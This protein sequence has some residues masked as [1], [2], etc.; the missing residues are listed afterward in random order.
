LFRQLLA[1]GLKAQLRLRS[2]I[3][4]QLYVA[5]DFHPE[6][7]IR[8]VGSDKKYPEIPTIQSPTEVLMSTLE[9]VPLSELAD[10]LV[11]VT[12]GIERTVNS[13]EVASSLKNL[14]VSLKDLSILLKN[15][16][17]EV[18]PLT[19]SLRD[20]SDAARGA[21]VQAEKT[22]SL[23]EGESGKLAEGIQ[24]T[25]KEVTAALEEIRATVSSYNQLAQNNA[26]I[27]YEVTRTLGEIEGAARSLRQLADYLDRHP[28]A[29]IKGKQPTKGE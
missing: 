28:E 7:P 16:N 1:K 29:L 19:T 23:K 9:K 18:Q 21:F 15:V 17:S 22:L 11:K 8:L 14:N 26:H 2:I 10:K 4:G 20:T 24:G 25:L 12:D 6:E 5:V 3:T 13:P 27:G